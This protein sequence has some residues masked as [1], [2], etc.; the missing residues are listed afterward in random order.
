MTL[1]Q[2]LKFLHVSCA[3][4][5]IAGFALRGYWVLT[6]NPMRQARLSRVLPHLVDTLLLVSAIA[7]LGIWGL[8][9]IELPWVSAKVLALLVYIAMGMVVMRFA[10]RKR[11]QL[12][13]YFA[14]L[15][16][17]AYI[18]AVALSHSPWGPLLLLG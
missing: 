9:P 13:A 3:L 4:A 1:F 17:A 15:L 14:A 8:S 7:M 11:D 2:V 5:S 6:D 18:V 16:A 12:L 10:T